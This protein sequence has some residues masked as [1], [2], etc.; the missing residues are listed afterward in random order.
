MVCR[1][2]RARDVIGAGRDIVL[3]ILRDAA[4]I[5]L[6]APDVDLIESGL[7]DSLSL[8]TLVYE[9]EQRCSV[10]IPFERL[11]LEAFRTVDSIARLVDDHA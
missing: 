5:E 8:V 4:G 11:D 10:S 1:A 3:A 7:L 2:V 6:T 9:L